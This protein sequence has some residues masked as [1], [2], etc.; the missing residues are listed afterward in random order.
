MNN[1]PFSADFWSCVSAV[2]SGEAIFELLST[3][4]LGFPPLMNDAQGKELVRAN[5]ALGVY[6]GDMKSYHHMC[7][8]YSGMF[9]DVSA[10]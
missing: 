8:F 7:R 1:E 5:G 10:L 3:D 9:Y 4:F 2:A 6:K